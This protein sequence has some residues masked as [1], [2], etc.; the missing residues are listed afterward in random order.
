MKNALLLLSAGYLAVGL[1]GCVTLDDKLVNAL[2]KDDAS[3]CASTDVRGGVGTITAPSGGY[4]Q[5]TLKL[6]RSRMPGAELT[7]GED[8]SMSIKNGAA[9]EP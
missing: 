3:F 2:A 8:G 4:G 7:L 9:S 5:A 6:C 1:S